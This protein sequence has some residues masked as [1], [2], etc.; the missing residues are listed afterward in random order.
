MLGTSLC[1][2]VVPS[3]VGLVQHSRLG[4]VDWKMAAGALLLEALDCCEL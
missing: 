1:A 3:V 2:M 4:N